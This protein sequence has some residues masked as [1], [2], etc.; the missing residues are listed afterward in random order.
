[1]L[2]LSLWCL[3]ESPDAAWLDQPVPH[4]QCRIKPAACASVARQARPK[5]G[6]TP[7]S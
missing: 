6:V 2:S 4:C 3:D 1:V 5:W 7:T